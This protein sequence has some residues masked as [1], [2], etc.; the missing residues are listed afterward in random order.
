MMRRKVRVFACEHR[1]LKL[2]RN[3]F[4][5]H[6]NL[7]A[8][9]LLTA[10]LS[11]ANAGLDHRRGRWILSGQRADVRQRGRLEKQTAENDSTNGVDDV[12]E[13]AEHDR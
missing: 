6:P 11:L 5:R 7:H 10:L 3:L 13:D 2:R 12:A 8:L 9:R 4:E 1:A